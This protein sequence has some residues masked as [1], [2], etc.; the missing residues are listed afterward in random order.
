MIDFYLNGRRQQCADV[1]PDT[2]V[3]ELLRLR[4]GQTG[5]KEGCASGDC[6]ACTVAIG[7]PDGRGNLSYHSAN[8][9]IMPAHQLK[10][11]HL[12]TVEGLARGDALHPAQAAMVDCHASQCGFCT[13]GIVMSLFTLHQGQRQHP[14]PLTQQRLESALGGNLCRCT[15]YRPIRDAALC[16]ADYPDTH[17]LWADDP[18]LAGNVEALDRDATTIPA[19]SSPGKAVGH[20]DSPTDIATLRE[21]RK[22]R[23]GSR[24]V[25][26]ATDLWL[27]T[28]QQLKPLEDLID[29]RQVAELTTIDETPAGFWIGAAVTFSRLEPLFAEHY[30][31]FAHLMHRF[32]S[33]QIRN[34]A[35]L[36]GN[37]ANA[38]PI[39]DTPP[40]LLALDA[41]LQLDGPGGPRE[42]AIADFFLDYRKTALKE[43]EFLRALFLPRLDNDRQ[44]KVWKLSKRREDD[45]SAVLGAFAWRLEDG[46]MRDVHLAF[47]GMA[48]IPKRAAQAEAALEGQAPGQPAFTTAL[49]A[50]YREFQPL[51]DVRGSRE[52]RLLAAGNLLERLRLCLDT[53]HEPHAEVCLDA[54]A[55]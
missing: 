14:A 36:G 50:L 30:P 54:Y 22:E 15:G 2:S 31:A 38:S 3:L 27:E 43:G 25:A 12:V 47:G 4:L 18:D 41:R 28:T 1:S 34:R 29:V 16:M 55:H 10:G 35:T 48:A 42:I 49:A 37:V 20:F 19:R 40:V 46:K 7:E 11:R 23:P 17:P 32:A 5:T 45:I 33:A 53:D 9:C 44:L 6:G 26:G 51:S 39:G 8:A 52:Y 13:P 21:L 24:L